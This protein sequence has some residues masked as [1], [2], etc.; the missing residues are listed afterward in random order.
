MA[1]Q[2]FID[3]RTVVSDQTITRMKTAYS[4]KG[5]MKVKTEVDHLISSFPTL[6]AHS[7]R[8]EFLNLFTQEEALAL[9]NA[10][11]S[12]RPSPEM[13][14]QPEV[15]YQEM[16]DVEALESGISQ[17][18]AKP[19]VLLEKVRSLSPMGAYI[20][21]QE[22]YLWWQYSAGSDSDYSL[23]FERLVIR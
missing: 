13:Q 17:Y 23:L 16:A 20:V 4:L 14:C 10:H 19:G 15:L 21:A 12:Y 8:R 22:C 11:N 2:R 1:E 5:K 9:A 6:Y 18:G 7:K 3:I